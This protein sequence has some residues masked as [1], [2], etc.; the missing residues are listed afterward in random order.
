MKLNYLSRYRYRLV[1][2]AIGLALM[3]L[4]RVNF[5]YGV[6]TIPYSMYLYKNHRDILKPL[7]IVLALYGIVALSFDYM[8]F[9]TE[10]EYNVKVISEVKHK[11]RTSFTGRIKGRKVKVYLDAI[12]ND[13]MP[14][15]KITIKGEIS[16][17][18]NNTIPKT[19]SYKNYLLSS[20]IKYTI[21]TEDYERI[22]TSFHYTIIKYY[23]SKYIDEYIPKSSEYVKTFILADKSGFD[24]DLIKSVN[25]LGISHLFA[26]SGLHVGVLVLFT[27]KVYNK[28]SPNNRSYRIILPLLF[29][30]LLLT[31][32]SPSIVRASLMY[33][34][35]SVKKITK[36]KVST[37]DIL[38]VIF[39]VLILLNPY[40]YYNI[41]F[42]LSFSV[43]FVI[44]ISRFV[45]K[46]K[47]QINQ[48]LL[49]TFIA[50]ISTLPIILN[51]NKQIN[52]YTLI[53]NI[54]MIY[55]MTYIILPL[56]YFT[57]AIYILDTI[58]Y[59]LLKPFEYIIYISSDINF[60]MLNFIISNNILIIIYYIL[61][62][63]LLTCIQKRGK[64]YVPLCLLV[65]F[66]V[67]CNNIMSFSPFKSVNMIDIYGDSILVIDSF[68]DCNILIDTGDVDDYDKVINY[69]KGRNI[70]RIDL[71]I[72]THE[73]DDH[74][75]ERN[76]LITGFKVNRV[77]DSETNVFED[78]IKCGSLKLHFY[79][80]Y[81][82]YSNENNHSLVFSLHIN[83][84]HYL[85]T[86]DME[87][88][89]ESE[90]LQLYDIDVDYLKSGHHGSITSST[91][92]FLDDINA[93]NVLISSYRNNTHGHPHGDII[94]RY[95]DKGMNIYRTD[96]LG[97][98]EI[99]YIF[100]I[101]YKNYHKP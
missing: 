90:F 81:R 62:F 1:Y 32:F 25:Y 18:I 41:G 34:G 8:P 78:E 2:I 61:I 89:K 45:T 97:T 20:N 33:M 47:N 5:I 26:V 57:F 58:Y 31:S 99:N 6:L 69:I 93:E 85:F 29:L 22:S 86:G 44:L 38:S 43:T 11:E 50:F 23:V 66:L 56:G 37:L 12:D 92:A 40:Y 55:Y 87:K 39:V 96:L 71:L 70:R 79:K 95:Q 100:E 42:I 30:Y 27:E 75:G 76:D 88:D 17:P 80:F 83:D 14:G 72:L 9:K 51:I 94:M 10:S 67:I 15:D 4:I 52:L 7:L 64:I 65:S 74:V 73:H 35:L 53:I 59:V 54:L 49:I 91:N 82:S 24:E 36:T 3:L 98:I 84:D 21:F 101:E 13:I 28:V 68:D 77:I 19:F 46:E 48:V 60:L 63:S 16:T